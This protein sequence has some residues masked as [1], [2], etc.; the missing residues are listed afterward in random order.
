MLKCVVTT[1]NICPQLH[2]GIY[3]IVF[4]E[5]NRST[6]FTCTRKS[7]SNRKYNNSVLHLMKGKLAKCF[8][9]TFNVHYKS[10]FPII[11]TQ[12]SR[13]LENCLQQESKLS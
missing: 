2:R 7:E 8:V 5:Q 6:H 3:A 4:F 1:Q 9:H 12:A 11:N 10:Y 13:E